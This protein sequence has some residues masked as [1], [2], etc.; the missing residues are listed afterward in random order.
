MLKGARTYLS[1][2]G[3]V[4]TVLAGVLET[5]G[6]AI[7]TPEITAAIVGVLVAFAAYFRKHA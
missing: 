2:L 6:V 5:G 1:L 4:L 3:I 7:L